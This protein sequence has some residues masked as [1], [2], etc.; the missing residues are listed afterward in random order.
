MDLKKLTTHVKAGDIQE[1]QLV[2]MEG[3]SYVIQAVM[4]GKSHPVK[5][6]HGDTFHVASVDEARKYLAGVP[7]VPLYLVHPTVYDEMVGQA[8]SDAVPTREPIPFRS[9]L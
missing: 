1:I 3:G 6:G 2:T 4:H 7:E 9:S 8:D 5:D